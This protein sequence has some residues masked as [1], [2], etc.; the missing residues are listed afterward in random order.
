MQNEGQQL[1]KKYS[2]TEW[3]QL[4]NKLSVRLR[5]EK[6]RINYKIFKYDPSF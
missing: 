6:T 2:V 5:Q 4:K 1:C 3:C